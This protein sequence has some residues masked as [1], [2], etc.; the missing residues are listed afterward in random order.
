MSEAE[1]IKSEDEGKS[2]IRQI[3]EDKTVLRNLICMM[4]VWV[5]GSFNYFLISYQLKYIEGNMY[6]N[7][8]VSSSS[9][10]VA[11]MVAGAFTERVG[12]KPTL[13]ISYV[14]AIFGMAS[15]AYD[16]PNN[17]LLLAI[18]VL[19]SKYGVS[20][21]FNVAYYANVCIFPVRIVAS[22]YGLCNIVARICTV[23]AP[24]VAEL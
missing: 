23:F 1:D 14:I 7:S 5:S 24:Y 9:E 17:Q 6:I 12:I 18:F 2:K 22:S 4:I 3:M 21:V 11:F 8:I 15:L 16:K 10:L 13:L 19:G 20:Q